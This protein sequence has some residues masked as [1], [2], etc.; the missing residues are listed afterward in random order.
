MTGIALNIRAMRHARWVGLWLMMSYLGVLAPDVHAQTPYVCNP[1]RT[2]VNRQGNAQPIPVG[3]TPVTVLNED[4]SACQRLIRNLGAAPMRCLPLAQ[5]VP[6]AT[7]GWLIGSGQDFELGPE[8]REQW[9]CV[10]TTGTDTSA[11]T[12]EAI[13]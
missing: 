12:L 13:Q 5:G 6:T 1:I 3:A 2:P 4:A 11:A 9:R 8:G 10:R 7:A